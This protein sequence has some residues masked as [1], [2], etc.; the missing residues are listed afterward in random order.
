MHIDIVQVLRLPD[1]GPY[2]SFCFVAFLN[3]VVYHAL[4]SAFGSFFLGAFFCFLPMTTYEFKLNFV[5]GFSFCLEATGVL[6][7]VSYQ[8]TSLS[9][10]FLLLV[11]LRE[12]PDLSTRGWL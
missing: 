1:G 10:S 6:G 11:T 4:P 3:I 12:V 9:C 5:S 8:S 7:G 2:I